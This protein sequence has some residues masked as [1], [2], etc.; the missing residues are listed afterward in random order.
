MRV[1]TLFYPRYTVIDMAHRSSIPPLSG[2]GKGTKKAPSPKP[3]NRTVD[4]DAIEKEYRAGQ[5][6]NCVIAKNHG[7]TEGAIR[8]RAKADGWA[9]DLTE[10][11]RRKVRDKLVRDEVRENKSRTYSDDDVIE[12]A[13]SRGAEVVRSH[14]NDIRRLKDVAEKLLNE[15]DGAPAERETTVGFGVNKKVVTASTLKE[16][17][18]CLRNISMAEEKRI[19]LE[20]QAFNLDDFSGDDDAPDSIKITLKRS[21]S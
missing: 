21:G 3:K 7:I 6:S 4:W 12:A 1:D 5:L 11:V 19:K 8:K 15:L 9:K 17:T 20:R 10:A 13:A 2:K 18:E 16:R 14:R